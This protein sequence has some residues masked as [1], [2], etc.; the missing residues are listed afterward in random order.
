MARTVV[1]VT[2]ISRAGVAPPAQQAAD[3]ANGNYIASNDGTIFVEIENT[4]GVSRSVGFVIFGSQVDG[5][6]IPDK[7]V[8]VPSGAI[9]VAGPFPVRF[10]GQVDQSLWINPDAATTLK[11]RAYKL[12]VS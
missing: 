12:P 11:L 3:H 9:R 1:P 2:E 5:V 6:T 4:D 8:T 10:Y 7:V